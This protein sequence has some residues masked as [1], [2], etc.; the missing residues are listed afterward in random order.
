MKGDREI[1]LNAGMD[2]HLGKPIHPRELRAVLARW[3]KTAA[4]D[5]CTSVPGAILAVH[6]NPSGC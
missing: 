1:S 5:V 6:P 3:G 2:D 4:G